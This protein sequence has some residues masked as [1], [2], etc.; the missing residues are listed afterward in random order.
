[1]VRGPVWRSQSV[2]DNQHRLTLWRHDGSGFTPPWPF[3]VQLSMMRWSK[4]RVWIIGLCA[5]LAV[6]GAAGA[7]FGPQV[8]RYYLVLRPRLMYTPTFPRGMNSVPEP[9]TNTTASTAEGT[10][11]SYYGYQFDVPWK[12]IVTET[13]P[14][15]I[16]RDGQE[17]RL[18]DPSRFRHRHA[19]DGA[20]TNHNAEEEARES[21]ARQS[22]YEQ[23]KAMLSMTPAQL[24]PFFSHRNFALALTLLSWKSVILEHNV[25]RPDIFSFE[26]PNY[27]GFE[28]SGLSRGWQHV[29]ID[30]FDAQDDTFQVFVSVIRDSTPKVTQADINRIIQSFGVASSNPDADHDTPK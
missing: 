11:L 3:N 4:H 14:E 8:L 26:T 19:R 15:I 30:L 21:I 28:I 1:M 9:L 16:F 29:E 7:Y 10:T 13:Y 22:W 20:R 18:G 25:A 17:V 24:S 23:Y 6:I 5:L 27:R 12:G 2:S